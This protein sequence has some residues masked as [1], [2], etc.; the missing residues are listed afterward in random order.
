LKKL[1]IDAESLEVEEAFAVAREGT[2]VT[3]PEAKTSIQGS[4]R[5]LDGLV[6]FKRM[7]GTAIVLSLCFYMHKHL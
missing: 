1:Q 3:R 7:T 4:R 2:K 6:K 5:N